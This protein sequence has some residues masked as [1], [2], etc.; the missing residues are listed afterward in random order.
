[1]NYGRAALGGVEGREVGLDV[2]AV[3]AASPH[4]SVSSFPDV[5]AGLGAG[6]RALQTFHKKAPGAKVTPGARDVEPNWS[7]TR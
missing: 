2:A 3:R 1:M 5:W 4:G 6:A 7:A